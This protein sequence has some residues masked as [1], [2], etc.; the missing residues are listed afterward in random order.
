MM[1]KSRHFIIIYY[2][3]G[4]YIPVMVLHHLH[5]ICIGHTIIY[6]STLFRYRYLIYIKANGGGCVVRAAHN[7]YVD[8]N[9]R[10]KRR[11]TV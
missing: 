11:N 1:S 5:L 2:D 7:H 9:E 6:A 4:M 8:Y 3:V 10:F